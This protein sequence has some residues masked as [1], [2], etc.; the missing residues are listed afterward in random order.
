LFLVTTIKYVNF[1]MRVDNDCERGVIAL[2]ALL[3]VKKQHRSAIVARR[4]H[5]SVTPVTI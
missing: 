4:M 3:G 2:L 5:R 1:A